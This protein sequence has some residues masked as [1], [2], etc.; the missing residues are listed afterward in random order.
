MSSIFRPI[1]CCHGA[2]D[3]Q[4]G[5]NGANRNA[6]AIFGVKPPAK[7]RYLGNHLRRVSLK[8]LSTL[9]LA[10]LLVCTGCATSPGGFRNPVIAAKS[11][12]VPAL[13]HVSP[14]KEVFRR[15][16]RREIAVT[17]SGFIITPDGYVV[18]NEHVA[19]KSDYVLCVLSDKD[20]VEAEVVGTDPYT[21]IAVLKLNTTRTNLPY[22]KMGI[23][24]NLEVGE[25]VMAM[26]SPHGLSRSVSLG[27]V[28]VTD[29]NLESL[30]SSGAPYNNW[31]QTD[32][33]INPGNSGGP[34]V[35]LRGEVIGINTR[36][37]SGADNVGFA[38]PI[39]IARQVVNEIIAHGRVRR[40]DVGIS[41]QEMTRVTEDPTRKGVVIGD[42]DPLYPAFEARIRPGDVLLAIDG[43]ETNARFTEDLPAIRK[44]IADVPPGQKIVLSIQ[45]GDNVLDVPLITVEKSER[46][47]DEEELEEWGFT[48]SELTTSMI[49]RAQLPS[50]KGVF[51]S[52][53]KQGEIA[54]RSNLR[55]GDIILT[56]DGE[57]VENLADFKEKY[58]KRVDSKQKLVL[59]TIKQGA[60]TLYRM[61]KQDNQED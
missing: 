57:T 21:D 47:G 36:K 54:A 3:I 7:N 22:V 28:S 53:T 50:R 27:I 33:A 10:A 52:G 31:I 4:K 19:G 39:D 24:A 41:F 20:E 16:E 38:I 29:R 37:L 18:T 49:R 14:V 45:R 32:A 58:A 8:R 25:S 43:N 15:G 5:L 30:G 55:P 34:L 11:K 48:L 59:L 17:G 13:V 44:Q 2:F 35:N 61:V 60:L 26:G 6:F 1:C 42:V 46:K 51:I 9:S 23:S 40:S 12:V 56:M